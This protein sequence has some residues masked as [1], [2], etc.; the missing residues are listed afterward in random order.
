MPEHGKN[1]NS[2][3]NQPEEGEWINGRNLP[4]VLDPVMTLQIVQRYMEVE[5]NRNRRTL[6]WLTSSFLLVVLLILSA[7]LGFGIFILKN[8]HKAANMARKAEADTA[9]YAAEVLAFSNKLDVV[10]AGGEQFKGMLRQTEDSRNREST[11]LKTDLKRFSDWI[12]M[13]NSQEA[14]AIQELKA[15]LSSLEEQVKTRDKELADLRMRNM[16]GTR[17]TPGAW[18]PPE[19]RREDEE[20]TATVALAPGR[21]PQT[22]PG[23]GETG[24]T[25]RDDEAPA[26]VEGETIK[27]TA[28]PPAAMEKIT[29]VSFPNGDRYKGNFRDGLFDGWG[30]LAYKNGDR[31]E[32]YFKNDIK[33]G[34]GI[35]TFANGDRYVGQFAND[36]KSGKG[37][38]LLSDGERYVG[39]FKGDTPTG[40]GSWYYKNGNRYAGTLKNGMKDGNGA[41]TYFNGDLYKGEFRDDVKEGKGVYTFKDSA[42]YEGEFKNDKR[43]GKGVFTYADGGEYSGEFKDG[44]KHGEGEYT[45]PNGTHIRGVFKEDKFV[46]ALEE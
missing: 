28:P 23:I 11:V 22:S 33:S 45:Y 21:R 3:G 6:L 16:P 12:A 32:G 26:M 27:I 46:R 17:N 8:S 20:G 39:E 44:L 36:Q 25:V 18:R 42:R 14:K 13:N 15:K 10:A 19:R 4:K 24:V 40:K 34:E 5:R 30:E 29:I 41:L 38:L 9:A 35:Y 7:F 1:G 2:G 37:T 31:Y 43:H